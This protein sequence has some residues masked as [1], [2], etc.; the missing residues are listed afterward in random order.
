LTPVG[1][2]LADLNGDG[3]A[4]VVVG[5]AAT[6]QIAVRLSAAG[7]FATAQLLDVVC[8][9][10]RVI[11]GDLD[12]DGDSDLLVGCRFDSTRVDRL[13][14]V[15]N[16][17]SGGFTTLAPFSLPEPSEFV[18]IVRSSSTAK[19]DVYVQV[20]STSA[21]AVLEGDGSLAFVDHGKRLAAGQVPGEFLAQ[22]FDGNGIDL[23]VAESAA[24]SVALLRPSGGTFQR[25][26]A[27]SGLANPRFLRAADL[28]GDGLVDLALVT[29]SE[30]VALKN[31]GGM[32]GAREQSVPL[33][34]SPAN[35]EL[36]D[37]DRDGDLDAALGCV[38]SGHGAVVIERN[39]VK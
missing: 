37:E 16:D 17:G 14:V 7:S 19:P 33:A 25:S 4:D 38:D 24:G 20:P 35:L 13:V 28:D 27:A 29:D 12:G 5:Y 6:T 30:L 9:P 39:R 22:D 26:E 31:A 21:V 2:A 36:G 34:M 18:Q 1:P 10:L 15:R 32:L 11:A 3:S 23:A 8:E